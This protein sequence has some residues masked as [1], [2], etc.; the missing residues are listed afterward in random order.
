MKRLLTIG[1]AT[2]ALSLVGLVGAQWWFAQRAERLA[3]AAESVFVTTGEPALISPPET[4]KPIQGDVFFVTSLDFQKRTHFAVNRFRREPFEPV[5]AMYGEHAVAQLDFPGRDGRYRI[6][7]DVFRR[8]KVTGKIVAIVDEEP[9][10]SV[11]LVGEENRWTRVTLV[12]SANIPFRAEFSLRVEKAS[13][14]ALIGQLT[15]ERLG[16]LKPETRPVRLTRGPMVQSVTETSAVLTWET[17]VASD[18][19]V[20]FGPTSQL[21]FVGESAKQVRYHSAKLSGLE[22][23]REY[24]YRII[25]NG[26][27]LTEGLSFRTNKPAGQPFRFVVF[28][29]SGVGS[30]EQRAI[31]VQVEAAQPDFIVHT[32]DLIYGAGERMNYLKGFFEPYGKTITRV[33]FYPSLGNHDIGTDYGRPYLDTFVLPEN[34]P[35]SLTRERNYWFEYGDAL[36]IAVESNAPD[37]RITEVIAPWLEETIRAST[38]KWKFVYFHHPPYQAGARAEADP[39]SLK[40]RRHLTPVFERTLPS[41]VFV[42]HDHY[43]ARLRPIGGVR[44]IV[45]GAGGAPL[46]EKKHDYGVNEIFYNKRHSFTV[47]DIDGDLLTLTQINDKGELV[48][49]YEQTADR[50]IAASVPAGTN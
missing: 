12:E 3:L 9:T 28:G 14:G 50:K 10:G 36:F 48:D 21:G 15:F 17:N 34:G 4:F 40:T 1:M 16:D 18:E 8:K 19:R 47:V 32:G 23:G 39:D 25:G 27:K 13:A 29:D 37:W 22:P 35:P 6:W 31:A 33:G 44:Y 20:E 5:L 11:E 26:T 41:M 42:G 45:T 30:K 38:K 2:A 7:A 24:F 43:Y 46:Y 49:K